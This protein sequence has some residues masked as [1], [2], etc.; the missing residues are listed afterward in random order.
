MGPIRTKKKGYA[1]VIIVICVRMSWDGGGDD[2]TYCPDYGESS[3]RVRVRKRV[4]GWVVG[5]RYGAWVDYIC[6]YI[7]YGGVSARGAAA[8]PCGG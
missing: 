8:R 1:S 5:S 6:M 3:V 7:L 4:R 2:V